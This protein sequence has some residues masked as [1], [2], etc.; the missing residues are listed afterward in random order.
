MQKKALRLFLKSANPTGRKSDLFRKGGRM[1]NRRHSL[2]AINRLACV[3][4]VV[5]LCPYTA[6][7]AATEKKTATEDA[8]AP[9]SVTFVSLRN[10][11]GNTPPGDYFG[12][13][14]DRLRTGSCKVAFSSLWGLDQIAESAPIY[15]PSEKQTITAIE[16]LPESRFWEDV[17]TFAKRET[18]NIV[19]YIHGYKIG[20]NKSC[21]RAA[22]FQR[23]LDLHDRLILFS[24]PAD[25][26]LIKYS[27]DVS[28]MVW[29]IPYLEKIIEGLVARMGNGRVDVVAHSLGTRGVV[30]AL[31]RLACCRTTA[32]ILSELVLVAPD[33]DADNFGHLLPEI[34]PL[35]NQITVY[36]SE[37]DKALMASEEFN[38]HPRLG[39]AGDHLAVFKGV[40]TIDITAA[41][42][43]RLSGHIYHLYNPAVIDDLTFLLNTGKPASQRPGLREMTRKGLPYWRLKPPPEGQ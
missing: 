17:S 36:A 15:I 28:D 32:P 33:I 9:I 2:T 22:I 34:R 23:A 39:Q 1:G 19:L 29:S 12:G 26:K 16:A 42:M 8:G 25:G 27:W 6:S 3:I 10:K 4:A 20:F 40:Q 43:R 11:T 35:V 13:T 37:N 5:L 38:G 24:W 18:G 21:H 31:S 41:G 7:A 30:V 14:R